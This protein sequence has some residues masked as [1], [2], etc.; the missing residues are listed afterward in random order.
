MRKSHAASHSEIAESLCQSG[1]EEERR[2]TSAVVCIQPDSLLSS[3]RPGRT[4]NLADPRPTPLTGSPHPRHYRF[5]CRLHPLHQFLL[6]PLQLRDGELC[7][8]ARRGEVQTLAVDCGLL[9]LAAAGGDGDGA[10]G[11][12]APRRGGEGSHPGH[13]RRG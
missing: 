7:G 10:G 1:V 5:H 12:G 8:K 13:N 2:K 11:A 6:K 3:L 4:R 9:L